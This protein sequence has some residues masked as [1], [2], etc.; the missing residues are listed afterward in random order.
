MTYVFIVIAVWFAFPFTARSWQDTQINIPKLPKRKPKFDILPFVLSFHIAMDGGS[1]TR[2]AIAQA[3]SSIST[4]HLPNTRLATQSD[5]DLSQGMLQDAQTN[6]ELTPVALAIAIS[7]YSGSGVGLALE[8]LTSD[9]M[10]TR[11]EHAEIQAELAATKA[12]IAVLA[13]LPILGMFMGVMMGANPFTWLLVNR[14][15]HMC[16]A[17]AFILEI[18]GIWWIRRL[19]IRASL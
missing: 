19:I 4:D 7:E 1:S 17:L 8:N 3:L 5:G 13:G 9:V 2:N 6:P 15:G 10:Q 18:S 12:T 16:A 14:Y 11:N